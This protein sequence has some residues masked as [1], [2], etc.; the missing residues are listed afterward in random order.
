VGFLFSCYAYNMQM[1]IVTAL[2][3]LSVEGIVGDH[4]HVI[5]TVLSKLFVRGDEVH[6]AYKHR[7]ADFADLTLRAVRRDYI[8]ED[9]FWNNAM[10]PEVYLELR[11]VQ[12]VGEQLVHTNETDAEDWYIVMKKIDTSKD[13]IR[14]LERDVPSTAQLS[15]YVEVLLSRLT[16]LTLV[17][18]AGLEAFFEKGE[19]HIQSEVLGT[20]GWARTADDHLSEVDMLYAEKLLRRAIERESYFQ[21]PVETI[22]VVI[23]VNGENIL[24]LDEGISFIDVMP[25]KDEWRVHDAYFV[26]C[27]SSADVGALAGVAHADI[28]H[29]AYARTHPLPSETVRLVYEIASALIQVPYR[30]MVGRNDLAAKYASF[31]K[32]RCRELDAL[33]GGVD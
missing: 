10:A 13:L 31:V 18:R 22:S 29:E 17:R 12:H 26:V 1:N 7:T 8:G 3:Q 23:D 15:E 25:P 28:L 4:D 19:S 14:I 32:T 9:F 30:K 33:L 21:A 24:F 16:E 27:R 6:K 20:L 2:E 11:G 5:E